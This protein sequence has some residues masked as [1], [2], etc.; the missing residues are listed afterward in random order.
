MTVTRDP[1]PVEPGHQFTQGADHVSG[2]CVANGYDITFNEDEYIK[3][4]LGDR[5]GRLPRLE[6]GR[7]C[8][9]TF[10]ATIDSPVYL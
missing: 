3:N 8:W 1:H 2:L 9:N 4:Q 5:A 10:S 6:G 7:A